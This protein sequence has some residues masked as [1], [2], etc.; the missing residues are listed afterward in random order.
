M[1]VH[2]VIKYI[3]NNLFYLYFNSCHL[4]LVAT[5]SK[6]S[7]TR[8][9]IEIPLYFNSCHLSLLIYQNNFFCD[10]KI[11][12]DFSSLGRTLTLRYRKLTLHC[13][14]PSQFDNQQTLALVPHNSIISRP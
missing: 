14:I 6:F 10:Q 8:K 2:R 1:I 3:F 7:D 5:Q 13:M 11:Y 12:S 4:K 9:F